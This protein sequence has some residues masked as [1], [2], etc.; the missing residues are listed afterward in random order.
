MFNCI[1]RL[2]LET[3]LKS[4]KNETVRETRRL[5]VDDRREKKKCKCG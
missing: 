4:P 2:V 1:T 3:K 5:D